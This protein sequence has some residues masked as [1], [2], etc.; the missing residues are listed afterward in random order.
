MFDS[1]YINNNASSCIDICK[2]FNEIY[3]KKKK[4]INKKNNNFI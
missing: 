2:S 1:F 3:L 4:K